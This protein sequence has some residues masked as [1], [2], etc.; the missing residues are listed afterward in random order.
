MVLWVMPAM[1]ASLPEFNPQSLHRGR[2]EAAPQSCLL[3]HTAVHGGGS[4][5]L[6]KVHTAR[7]GCID[8]RVCRQNT[9]VQKHLEKKTKELDL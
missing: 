6:F 9:H 5:N 3:T 8:I 4:N 7:T 2:R 1:Q